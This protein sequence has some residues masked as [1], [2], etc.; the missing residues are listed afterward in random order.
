MKLKPEMFEVQIGLET[1]S[2][3]RPVLRT[4][5]KPTNYAQEKCRIENARIGKNSLTLVHIVFRSQ[6]SQIEMRQTLFTMSALTFFR[7]VHNPCVRF[8]WFEQDFR[9]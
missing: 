6:N 5:A 8:H 7:K 1:P 4:V 9:T 2:C 3:A